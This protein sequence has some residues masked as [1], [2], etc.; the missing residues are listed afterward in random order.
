MPRRYCSFVIP[1]YN[2][3]TR[4]SATL[5]AIAQ[6]S[7]SHLDEC[8]IILADDGSTDAT[9]E[10]GRA[11][12]APH[13]RVSVH[14][15]PH[16]GKGSAI[17]HGVNASRGD[18]IVLCDADLEQSVNEVLNLLDALENGADIAIG[19]RWRLDTSKPDRRRPLFRRV[20]SRVFN[21]VACHILAL[22]FKDTQCGLKALT[23]EAA[24][25]IFPLLN[26]RGWGYDAELIHV[27][28]ALRLRIEEVNLRLVHDYRDSHFRPIT[29]GCATFLELAKIRWNDFRGAYGRSVLG[30][31]FSRSTASEASLNLNWAPAPRIQAQHPAA[32]ELPELMFLQ[33]QP[34]FR[35]ASELT[36]A[37]DDFGRDLAA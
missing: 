32:L 9:A 25:S 13:C 2:E 36:K 31:T 6:F 28:L 17:R 10:I 5:N 21:V 3:E 29:D 19:S 15:L 37:P 26:L 12:C 11:F 20:S 24:N 27:A 7:A 34:D 22:P 14:S 16:Q 33:G 8:E 4:L 35:T 18:I 30:Q 1:S 23:R